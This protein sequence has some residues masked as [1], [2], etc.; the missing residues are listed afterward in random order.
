M[1]ISRMNSA[2]PRSLA[3][4]SARMTLIATGRFDISSSPANTWAMPPSP[5]KPWIT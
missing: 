4:N 5:S 3:A 2:R 1:L